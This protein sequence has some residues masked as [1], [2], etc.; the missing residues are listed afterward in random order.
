M[1]LKKLAPFQFMSVLVGDNRQ[2]PAVRLYLGCVATTW[3]EVEREV[4]KREAA[5][6]DESCSGAV[7]SNSAMFNKTMCITGGSL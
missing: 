5:S 7:F 4:E 3:E 2:A 1:Y 6:P